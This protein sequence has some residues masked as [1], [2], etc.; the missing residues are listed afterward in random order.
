MLLVVDDQDLITKGSTYVTGPEK[1]VNISILLLRF[2]R[3]R[4]LTVYWRRDIADGRDMRHLHIPL[5]PTRDTCVFYLFQPNFV[6]FCSY[7]SFS[8]F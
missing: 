3:D 1:V 6:N 4:I 2:A 5:E 7:F 8:C